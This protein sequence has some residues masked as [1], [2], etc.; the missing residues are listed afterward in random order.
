MV[1]NPGRVRKSE[2]D[3]ILNVLDAE[4]DRILQDYGEGVLYGGM[5]ETD[6]AEEVVPPASLKVRKTNKCL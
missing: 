2:L 5:Q 3:A 6:G 4:A 1:G